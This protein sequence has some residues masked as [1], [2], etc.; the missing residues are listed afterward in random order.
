M[1]FF[2]KAKAV[3]GRKYTALN[4]YIRKERSKIHKLN[5]PIGK[6]E[7]EKQFKHK[8]NGKKKLEHASINLKTI[9]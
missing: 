7:E 3:L 4:A 6:L 8:A 2:S 5:F 1:G 9:Y